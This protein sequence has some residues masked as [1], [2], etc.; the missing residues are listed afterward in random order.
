MATIEEVKQRIAVCNS[1]GNSLNQTRQYNIGQRESIQKQ[2]DSAISA[3]NAKYGT[4]I[5]V[6][7][8]DA[9]LTSVCAEKEKEIESVE[10]M[11][12]LIESGNFSEAMKLAGE[13]VPTEAAV[14]K[15]QT[16]SQLNMGEVNTGATPV[17]VAVNAPAEASEVVKKEEETIPTSS[18]A[19]APVAPSP[20]SSV[21][22]VDDVVPASPPLAS[23][24]A[25]ALAQP[26]MEEKPVAPAPPTAPSMPVS[27][28]APASPFAQSASGT[29]AGGQTASA[30]SLPG[31]G[32]ALS[33]FTRGGDSAMPLGGMENLPKPPVQQSP[34]DFKEILS[35]SDFPTSGV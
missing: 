29:V 13:A 22:D 11:I 15:A 18:P 31:F 20:V 10:Q 3:Y 26:A 2:L 16:T 34:T 33:G 1:K 28:T 24:A 4:S 30:Q 7:N 19:P 14:E 23:P 9:E 5:S 17:G 21:P 25:S 32:G 27:P 8:I 12:A 6:D 35:G